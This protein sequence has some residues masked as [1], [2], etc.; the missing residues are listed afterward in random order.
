MIMP[1]AQFLMICLAVFCNGT[2]IKK[3]NWMKKMSY[4]ETKVRYRCSQ[5]E[6]RQYRKTQLNLITASRCLPVRW[7][8][9]RGAKIVHQTWQQMHICFSPRSLSTQRDAVDCKYQNRGMVKFM[10]LTTYHTTCC[11]FEPSSTRC[12]HIASLV[13]HHDQEDS[14]LTCQ[15]VSNCKSIYDNIEVDLPAISMSPDRHISCL[16]TLDG[17]NSQTIIAWY[18]RVSQIHLSWIFSFSGKRWQDETLV[19]MRIHFASVPRSNAETETCMAVGTCTCITTWRLGML[20]HEMRD[21]WGRFEDAEQCLA[22]RTKMERFARFSWARIAKDDVTVYLSGREY[23]G[24]L[25]F[26]A[27]AMSITIPVDRSR[28]ITSA[29]FSGRLI[30]DLWRIS[31]M[32]SL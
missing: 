11:R 2:N 16:L 4:L 31:L 20:Y 13:F 25:L 28:K 14:H 6:W 26:L 32:M 7:Q 5:A 8:Y 30:D 1:I 22:L 18:H 24:A 29:S 10:L 15:Y 27:S 23:V 9:V 17:T 3:N 12:Q 19:Q 21:C